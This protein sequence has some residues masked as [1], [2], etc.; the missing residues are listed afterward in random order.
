MTGKNE[1]TE[2]GKG[3]ILKKVIIAGTRLKTPFE[4]LLAAIEASGWTG[5]I[6]EVVSAGASGV[7]LLGEHWAKM[8]GIPVKRFNADWHKFG[9]RAGFIRNAEM[10]EYADALIAL[11]AETTS[12]GT[13]DMV[14]QATAK[15]LEVFVYT[16]ED[17][18]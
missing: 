5:Y 14:D 2:P 16:L 4:T 17:P 15:G 3:P 1:H 10:A 8:H 9:G 11:P 12:I 7:D 13:W 18:E 6:C